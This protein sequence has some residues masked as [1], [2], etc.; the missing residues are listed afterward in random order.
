MGDSVYRAY[1][2]QDLCIGCGL[3]EETM[4][5]VFRLG[6]YT[7]SVVAT[8]VPEEQL[9]MLEIAARDCPVGAISILPGSPEQTSW[10]APGDHD[11]ESQNEEEGG[12]IGEYK[13]KHGYLTNPDEVEPNDSKRFE[14]GE[15]NLS[16]VR[17]GTNDN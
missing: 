1:V 2:D 16:V 8:F 3:C 6:D 14:R 12:E 9:P 13:R 4:P 15:H 7:V 11:Q 17:N 5:D 10:H